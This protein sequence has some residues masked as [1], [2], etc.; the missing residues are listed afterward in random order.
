MGEHLNI[1]SDLLK[2]GLPAFEMNRH[3]GE[4][5]P[6]AGY[7]LSY[8]TEKMECIFDGLITVTAASDQTT[9]PEPNMPQGPFTAAQIEA[10]IAVVTGRSEEHT[11]ELQSLMSISYAVFCL[12]KK[13]KNILHNTTNQTQHT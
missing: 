12:K 1:T 6:I 13:K 10:A 7:R 3:T 9:T 5:P 4:T 2:Q 11:S 8:M